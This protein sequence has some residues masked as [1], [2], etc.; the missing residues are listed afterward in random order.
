MSG[1]VLGS[2]NKLGGGNG[3]MVFRE[4]RKIGHG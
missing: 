1:Y 3:W 4:I 2:S